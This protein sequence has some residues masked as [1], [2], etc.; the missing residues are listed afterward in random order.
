MSK[1]QNTDLIE[2]WSINIGESELAN[3]SKVLRSGFLNEGPATLDLESHF[4]DYFNVKHAILTTSG[5][6]ALFLGLKALG[7]GPGDRVA[8][9]N[10]T[11][12]ATANAVTLTGATPVLIDVL[13]TTLC[14][15]PKKLR[16]QHL[17]Q[18]LQA[19][20]PVHVSG[21]SAFS[22]ELSLT[23]DELNL[24]CI[25][26]AAEAFGSK[27][28][29]SGRLLGSIGSLGAFSFS[30]N[31]IVTSGQ[32][33]LIITND[34]GVSGRI[35]EL[36]DQGRP[37]RGTG[38]D[39]YHNSIGFNFKFTDVQATILQ[40][41][42]EQLSQRISH[43]GDV[44]EYYSAQIHHRDKLFHF[45]VARGEFPLWPELRATDR[46]RLEL[47]FKERN[48]G[49]RRIWHPISSQIPYRAPRN[50]FPNS[51]EVSE[52]TLWIPSAFNLDKQKLKLII[53]AINFAD[54]EL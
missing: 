54:G 43:L 9:P 11:F 4:R 21:R 51:F 35:R 18:P 20:I 44:Y 3:V 1:I 14:I 46:T 27:D 7:I 52:S 5:T 23:M 12:I 33:G 22:E 36:K 28:P 42:L 30:P 31:K 48:I 53:E 24:L 29:V 8:V 32:G 50:E 49:F 38:G 37:S 6:V 17:I 26:D 16:E 41:Q 13:P 19:L 45:D 39:D 40:A 15:D 34:D 2:W 47:I 25:E 10:L